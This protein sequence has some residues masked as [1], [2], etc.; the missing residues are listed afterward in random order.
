MHHG[1]TVA[2]SQSIATIN[3]GLIKSERPYL[4]MGPGRWGSFDRW[5]GIPV[6]WQDIN[7]VGAIVEIRNNTL[8]ADPSHG[9]HFF[10]HITVSE[11]PY[12]TIT[13]GSDDIIDTDPHSENDNNDGE[14]NIWI[15]EFHYDNCGQDTGEFVEIAGTAGTNLSG[16][17]LVSYNGSNAQAYK[18]VQLTGTIP[19]ETRQRGYLPGC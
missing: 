19:D 2:I 14:Q 18:T 13:E 12:L 8:K 11:I 7:G 17:R 1:D 15:N 9:S 10:Q 6:K 3:K 5:L 4:L 16:Y